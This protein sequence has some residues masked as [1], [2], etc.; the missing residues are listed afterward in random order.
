LNWISS[1][2]AVLKGKSIL[3]FN[4]DGL[5]KFFPNLKFWKKP[6]IIR[7]KKD[8]KGFEQ[9]RVTQVSYSLHQFQTRKQAVDIWTLLD[10]L[11]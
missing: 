6:N 3:E 1:N 4:E 5:V 7:K 8:E 2:T 9:R 11:I 10:N